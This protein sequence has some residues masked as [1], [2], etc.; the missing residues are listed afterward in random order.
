MRM[1]SGAGG[2]RV[3]LQGYLVTE[4]F[5]FLHGALF[6]FVTIEA[7]EKRSSHFLVMAMT[8]QHGVARHQEAVS[9]RDVGPLLTAARRDPPELGREVGILGVRGSPGRFAHGAPEPL[10]AFARAA[11][12]AFPSALIVPRTQRG[13]TGQMGCTGVLRHVDSNLGDDAGATHDADPGQLHP[14]VERGLPGARWQG[15]ACR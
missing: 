7:V 11:T 13:P 5:E 8:A 2:S 12:A 1:N 14:V 10:V 3:S 15:S 4:G 9:H 6:D